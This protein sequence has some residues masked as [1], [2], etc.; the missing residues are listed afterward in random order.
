M[1]H[2]TFAIE[3]RTAFDRLLTDFDFETVEVKSLGRECYVRYHKGPRTVSIAWE[4]GVAPI[5][6][7][8]APARP[9]MKSPLGQAVAKYPIR[10]A[11][12]VDPQSSERHLIHARMT[13]WGHT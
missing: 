10:E 3:C 9:G 12:L 7:L 11:F 4:P 8:F 5:V 2:A 1:D 13:R 6:E